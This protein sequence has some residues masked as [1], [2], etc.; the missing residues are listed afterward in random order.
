MRKLEHELNYAAIGANMKDEQFSPATAAKHCAVDHGD[1]KASKWIEGANKWGN[2]YLTEGVNK[3]FIKLLNSSPNLGCRQW[4]SYARRLPGHGID[5]SVYDKTKVYIYPDAD[6]RLVAKALELNTEGC[7]HV[8]L[9]ARSVK[10]RR[11]VKSSTPGFRTRLSYVKFVYE[12][13]ER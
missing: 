5:Q 7:T 12:L 4:L 13:K 11:P 3:K 10:G 9:N 8:M 2:H 6:P 1:K